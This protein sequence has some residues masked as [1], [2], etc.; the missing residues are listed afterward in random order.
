MGLKATG[1]DRTLCRELCE[2]QEALEGWVACWVHVLRRSLAAVWSMTQS[3]PE[4]QE[5]IGEEVLVGVQGER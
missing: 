5:E 4:L 3:G 2:A 1:P